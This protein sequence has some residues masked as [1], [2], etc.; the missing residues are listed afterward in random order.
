MMAYG[1]GRWAVSQTPKT[2]VETP[3]KVISQISNLSG[4]NRSYE[5]K[6]T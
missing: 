2:T 4:E 3:V 6:D 1:M 5:I